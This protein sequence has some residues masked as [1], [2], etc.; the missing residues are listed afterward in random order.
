MLELARRLDLPAMP[1]LALAAPGN[2]WYPESFLAAR[3]RNQPH[4]GEALA[5]IEEVARAFESQHGLRREQ[6]AL[7]GFSQ[8]ACLACEAI[9]RAPRAWGALVAFTGG[10]HGPLG[11]SFAP[12]G[13]LRGTPVLLTNGDRDGWVPLERSE[14]TAALFTAMGASVELRV[15]PGRAHLVSEEELALARPLLARLLGASEG[16][17]A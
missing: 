2:T 17:A 14:Q 4:L 10:V 5:R 7:L 15:Y 9:H 13:A 16:E 1:F 11:T 3:E 8:G 12:T 6:I